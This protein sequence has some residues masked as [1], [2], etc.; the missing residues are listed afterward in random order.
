MEPPEVGPWPNT[1][2]LD[3]R[4]SRCSF[5]MREHPP[6]ACPV[7]LRDTARTKQYPIPYEHTGN[8]RPF[9]I[10]GSKLPPVLQD[11]LC[12]SCQ[13]PFCLVCSLREQTVARHVSCHFV[14][15]QPAPTFRQ[16]FEF[17]QKR[18]ADKNNRWTSSVGRLRLA[19]ALALC[20]PAIFLACRRLHIVR[21][22]RWLALFT[23]RGAAKFAHP[24][25]HFV[26]H[27]QVLVVAYDRSFSRI[28]LAL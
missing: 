23:L 25:L 24:R 1:E 21:L 26:H 20:A 16:G 12:S 3:R 28:K 18:R 6:P 2:N 17:G 8:T 19:A 11:G 4:Y 27:P 9:H 7:S 13:A 15:G 5:R 10:A 14:G 22:Y